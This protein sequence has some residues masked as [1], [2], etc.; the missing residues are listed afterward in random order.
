MSNNSKKRKVLLVYPRHPET[1]WSFT[2]ILRI[3]GKK[4]AFP[5]LGLLTV[6]SMLPDNW[7]KKLIDMNCDD[8]RDQ[9]I[10]WA[11]LVFISAMIVQKKSAQEVISKVKKI[12]KPI[13]AGGPLFTT[14][15]E[16]FPEVDHIVLGEAEAILPKFLSDIENGLTERI[17][18]SKEFPDIRKTPV[19]DWSLIDL[20]KYNSM[21]IQSSRGCPFDCEF[22]DVVRLNGRNPRVKSGDQIISELE[23]L[24]KAGWR[25][26][27]FFV[28][29]NFIGNRKKLKKEHL[30]AII[31]WQK[32]KGYPFSFN[33]Q[34]SIN[35]A[36]DDKL[37]KLMVEAG[38][39]AVF[40]GVETPDSGSLE[41]CGKYQNK[42][43]DMISAVK[44][45]QGAGLEVQGGF[46]VG[47]DH[48]TPSIFQRQIE[49]IQKS[50]I[51]TAMVGLLTA[52]PETRLYKRLLKAGRLI[53][54]TSGNNTKVSSLNFIPKMDMKV[55]IEGYKR[56]LSTIYSPKYY[57]QRVKTFLREF[58][59]PKR[60][61]PRVRFYHIK[62]FFSSLWLL[63]FRYKGKRYFW[64][65]ILW[66]LLRR[67]SML[68]YAVGYSLVGIHFRK[69]S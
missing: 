14:G 9:D 46:I 1:F 24:Y 2:H 47:F 4:A 61:L 10:K 54:E 67:P 53:K 44:K 18:S 7:E 58:K 38:F 60:K 27:V 45:L 6:A 40:V 64:R 34:A 43:R 31:E 3:L 33:T 17:Y 21:C 66:S 35:L 25:G 51:V 30:P 57:Y 55:L 56:I 42:N 68:P 69:I 52:L 26:G 65:L 20:K 37:I 16:E 8:L 19:P 15:W 63:G 11:D 48:D 49:F 29:D 12:G 41:E 32:E 50:G 28:D 5:P 23:S 13:V 59:P 62:A 22:C 36:D 39:T